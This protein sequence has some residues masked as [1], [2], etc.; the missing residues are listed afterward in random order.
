[1]TKNRSRKNTDFFSVFVCCTS[2]TAE[3]D[4]RV[5][6]HNMVGMEI[7]FIYIVFQVFASQITMKKTHQSTQTQLEIMSGQETKVKPFSSIKIER[8]NY[9]IISGDLG[10]TVADSRN[11]FPNKVFWYLESGSKEDF[12]EIQAEHP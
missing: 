3:S 6:R 2:C 8:N 11:F 9:L 10:H 7:T 4:K 12:T 1:M 5:C